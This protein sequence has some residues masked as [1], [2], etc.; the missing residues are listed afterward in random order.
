MRKLAM[1]ISLAITFWG[2]LGALLFASASVTPVM[3]ANPPALAFAPADGHVVRVQAQRQILRDDLTVERGQTIED[4][5]FIYSG[6][7]DLQGG[8][9]ITGDLIVFSGNVDIA[10]DASV[11]GDVT[12]YSGNITVAG[13]VG[14]DLA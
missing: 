13:H 4:D 1:P 14:G 9:R 3:A 8:G 11:D 12:N 10:E 6:N 5:V 2:L 7:V